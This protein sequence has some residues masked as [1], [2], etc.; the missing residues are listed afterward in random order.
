[1]FLSGFPGVN[2]ACVARLTCT[3]LHTRYTRCKFSNVRTHMFVTLHVSHGRAPPSHVYFVSAW[4][5]GIA[6]PATL[7]G[8]HIK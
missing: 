4:D 5:T 7:D 2:L 6:T 8:A 1:M 3:Y